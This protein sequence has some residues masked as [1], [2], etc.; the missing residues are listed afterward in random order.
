MKTSIYV[1]L[2]F[3]FLLSC[4]NS[5]KDRYTSM[6]TIQTDNFEEHPGKI[7]MENNCYVCHN[8]AASHDDL[9]APPMIA[10]K[11]RYTSSQPTKAE[12]IEAIQTWIKNPNEANAKMYGAVKRFNVMPKMPFSEETIA[13]IADYMYEYDIA[14]PEW[15]EGHFNE[16]KGNRN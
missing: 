1:L 8:L 4:E 2:T 16:M 15:F 14:Q 9:L 11:R 3:M 5:E 10:V 7:L 12:F 6:A 13:Q